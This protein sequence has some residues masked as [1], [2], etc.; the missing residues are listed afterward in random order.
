MLEAKDIWKSY[1][2]VGVLKGV[3]FSLSPAEIVS[4]TGKSGS[5]KSTLLHILG[6]LDEMDEGELLI[7]DINVNSLPEKK[8]AQLRNQTLGFVFQF[9]HLLNEFN[10]LE[11]VIIPSLISK[12]PKREAERKGSELLAYLGLADRLDHKPSMLSGGEQQRVAI[13]RAMM[14]EP[15]ILLADEPTGN[16]D[17][18][19]SE[20]LHNLFIRLRDDFDQAIVIV[21][22]NIE[23]AK[24]SDRM[25]Q[26]QAGILHEM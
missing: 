21:T 10:A 15:K 14:N 20:H 3:N 6:T 24:L 2:N 4:I 25:L 11:N 23:L 12:T 19:A 13:A 8:I 22:H 16:L 18:E 26:M 17:Q 1:G 5:G 9:H 7:D